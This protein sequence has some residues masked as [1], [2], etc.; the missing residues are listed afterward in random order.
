MPNYFTL[1]ENNDAAMYLPELTI[2]MAFKQ[3]NVNL[4][5]TSSDKDNWNRIN[6]FESD[7]YE[8]KFTIFVYTYYD[9]WKYLTKNN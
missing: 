2:S 7:I 6:R 4:S 9:I 8:G 5:K 3:V 1:L